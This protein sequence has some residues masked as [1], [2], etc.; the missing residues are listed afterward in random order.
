MCLLR[1]AFITSFYL[2]KG[3]FYLIYTYA[4]RLSYLFKCFNTAYSKSVERADPETIAFHEFCVCM[5]RVFGSC[6]EKMQHMLNRP[7]KVNKT[8]KS[9]NHSE[10]KQ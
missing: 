8:R 10:Q 4:E 3:F 6:I 1:S 7:S 2:V 9:L 5:Q